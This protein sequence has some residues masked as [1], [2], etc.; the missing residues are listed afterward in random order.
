MNLEKASKE[1]MKE[2]ALERLKLLGIHKNA[3]KEFKEENIL[4]KSE[5]ILGSLY[6]LNEEEEE[7]VRKDE[8]NWNVLV[9]HIILT[10][11]INNG[12]I[13]DLL[14]I[15]EEKQYWLEERVRLKAGYVL[16]HTVSQFSESGDIF[17]K[18]KNGGLVRVW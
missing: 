15:T 10:N 13:Y 9:Y 2:E 1:E 14:F 6:W 3:I 7:M 11:T 18:N 4:N 16:S 12:K 17:V 5:G 8:K